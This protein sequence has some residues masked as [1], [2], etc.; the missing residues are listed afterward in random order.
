[1][2]HLDDVGAAPAGTPDAPWIPDTASPEGDRR[3]RP[4]TPR[5]A[6]A[7]ASSD[8]VRDG[9]SVRGH[10]PVRAMRIRVG[11]G[12]TIALSLLAL[13]VAVGASLVSGAGSTD[14]VE[15]RDD[16]AGVVVEGRQPGNHSSDD[17]TAPIFVH[18]FGAVSRP[19]L[20]ELSSGSRVVDAVSAAGGFTADADR[21]G[22]NLARLVGDAEQ[23]GVPHI[24]EEPPVAAG[25]A[26][27]AASGSTATGT[28]PGTKVS[29]NRASSEELQTLP[30]VGPATAQSIIAWR[31]ENGAFT[32]VEQLL[33]ISGIGQKTYDRL[34]DLV[35]T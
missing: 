9:E 14:V 4:G 2:D 22:L 18:V 16:S 27:S 8:Q 10:I 33:S 5:H 24:G 28:G 3:P 11:V 29:L 1:V 35:T 13:I 26:G 23:I 12:A 25:A 15:G 30:Q 31:T 32:S 19:G 6:G 21:D 34:K 20:Y 7:S 17:D